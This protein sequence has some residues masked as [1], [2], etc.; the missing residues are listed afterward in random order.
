MLPSCSVWLWLVSAVTDAG[1]E[2][3]ESS[4]SP[5]SMFSP[6]EPRL[7]LDICRRSL[8][9]HRAT[10]TST[11][12]TCSIWQR[13]TGE[14]MQRCSFQLHLERFSGSL[15]CLTCCVPSVGSSPEQRK[16]RDSVLQVQN[17]IRLLH[18][19]PKPVVSL[20]QSMDQRS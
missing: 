15:R 5:P 7:L 9:A 16:N 14:V 18:D 11:T 12:T 4:S 8:S 1:V 10:S 17:K 19:P 6:L 13:Y 20:H 2:S 3:A